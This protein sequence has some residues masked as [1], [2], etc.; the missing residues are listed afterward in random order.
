MLISNNYN[1]INKYFTNNKT[2]LIIKMLIN[3]TILLINKNLQLFMMMNKNSY[4][5]I[6]VMR[7]YV[8]NNNK[9]KT[10]IS[11]Q[12]NNNFQITYNNFKN[13][14]LMIIKKIKVMVK[15]III[16]SIKNNHSINKIK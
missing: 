1:N 14:I 6:Q 13:K 2:I 16:I 9:F 4:K 5:I 8:Y 7:N 12:I 15:K 11:I 3:K 10:V